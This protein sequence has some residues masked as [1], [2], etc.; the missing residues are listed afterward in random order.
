MIFHQSEDKRMDMT[1]SPPS[2][3]TVLQEASIYQKFI[4]C[5]FNK[6]YINLEDVIFTN[7]HAHT[8]TEHIANNIKINTLTI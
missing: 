2:N 3:I 5:T 4:K 8:H 7:T 6:L 1:S